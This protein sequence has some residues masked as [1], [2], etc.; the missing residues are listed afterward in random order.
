[1]ILRSC[2]FEDWQFLLSL[3]ND[4]LTRENSLNREKVDVEN[5]KEWLKNSLQNDNRKIY[6]AEVNNNPVG[7]IRE[8]LIEESNIVLSWAVSPSS[9]G[10]GYGTQMLNNIT[11]DRV[12]TFYAHIKSSNVPSAKMALKNNFTLES[13]TD[14]LCVYKKRGFYEIISDIENVRRN[15]N[16][17]WMDVLRLSFKTAPK[18]AKKLFCEINKNDMKVSELLQ[19]LIKNDN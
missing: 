6:I 11:N 15:N 17:K 8:D 13:E 19:E 18:E 10:R 1:M 16:V 2:T 12:E 9:R 5:H 14:S 4:P 7:M 3:R